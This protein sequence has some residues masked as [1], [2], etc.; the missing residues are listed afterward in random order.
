M[1]YVGS[2]IP[3]VFVLG[4]G[5]HVADLYRNVSCVVEADR[6][7]LTDDPA[8]YVEALYGHGGAA[9]DGAGAGG[10]GASGA[11]EA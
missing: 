7:V 2:E 5:Q 9:A 1:K 11:E 6:A 4:Y 3:D 10:A 8:A